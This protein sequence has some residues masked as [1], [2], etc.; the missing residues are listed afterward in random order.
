MTQVREKISKHLDLLSFYNKRKATDERDRNNI[1][2]TQYESAIDEFVQS[3]DSNYS[4]Y[5]EKYGGEGETVLYLSQPGTPRPKESP[6][7]I[8]KFTFNELISVIHKEYHQEEFIHT[9][10]VN[11]NINLS[12]FLERL[13]LLKLEDVTSKLGAVVSV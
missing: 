9:I 13:L 7:F 8:F 1:L 2:A 5:Y 12:I 11:Q 4:V 3:L 10:I 6:T